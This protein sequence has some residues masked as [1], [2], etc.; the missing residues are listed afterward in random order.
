[1]PIGT[2][3]VALGTAR[4]STISSLKLNSDINVVYDTQISSNI[5]STSAAGYTWQ[6][7]KSNT[8]TISA[9]GLALGVKTT[10]GAA[11]ISTNDYRW[12]RSIWG[13][14]IQQTFGFSD[15]IFI[16]GAARFDGS[17]VFGEDQRNQFY[18]KVSG[19]Y[20]ISEEGFW[21]GVSGIFNNFKIR[22]AWGQAGNLTAIGPFDRLSNYQ[23]VSINGISGLIS[24]TQLGNPDLK[25]ERQTE[26]ELGVDMALLNNRLGVEFTYY[27][28]DIQDL[29]LER[30]LSP[31][32][33]ASSRIENIGT[34]TNVGY[35]VLV[36]AAAVQS[37]N[38][39]W[40]I[41]ATF[42]SN[43]NEVG[44]IEGDEFGIGNFGFAKAKNGYPLGVF[45]Q[46]YYARNTDGS[47][48]LTPG[49]LPQ[50]ERGSVDENDNNIPERDGTGQPSGA[51][52]QKVIGDPNPD[53]LASLIN[54]FTY[55]NWSFRFQFDMVQGF[56]ILSWDERMFF[57]FGGG[58]QEGKELNGE[59]V[60]GT[61]SAKFGIAEAYIQDGSF[62][63]LRELS[64]SYLMV[65]PFKGMNDI[66]FTLSGRNLFSID[67]FDSWDPEVNMDA[68]S[69]GS[70]GGVMGLI[71]IPRTIK[72]GITA[73]F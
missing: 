16:T 68:Q 26:I 63:K 17:S 57:R 27:S 5:T 43:K 34:M 36:N 59:E 67:N 56:D 58:E 51:A 48:L 47:L 41:I 40:D 61:G 35:E 44:G 62:T 4:T 10:N 52:L 28:Q 45:K 30:L 65:K 13:G 22:G 25:P 53:F 21:D 15:K 8:T 69:N 29:L 19:S 66:R 33:G 39:N 46:G 9:S 64:L 49:G 60:R 3:T 14:Y 71:P 18:P 32:T 73:N 20:V 72:F 23:P 24:P 50:R 7:D 2:N 42:S 54:E 11:T 1:M 70:R 38:F 12:E 31:S 37:N 6:Y 55:K